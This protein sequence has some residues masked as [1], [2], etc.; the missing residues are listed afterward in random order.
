M[1]TIPRDAMEERMGFDVR[2]IIGVYVMTYV[3]FRPFVRVARSQ[4]SRSSFGMLMIVQL[5]PFRTYSMF[6]FLKET[7]DDVFGVP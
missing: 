6:L 2:C 4:Q 1:K 7:V 5:V 3:D